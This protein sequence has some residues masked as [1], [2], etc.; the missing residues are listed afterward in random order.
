[1][2]STAELYGLDVF[3][4]RKIALGGTVVPYMMQIILELPRVGY[5]LELI[6]KAMRSGMLRIPPYIAD[7]FENYCYAKN[8]TDYGRLFDE[9]AYVDTDDGDHRK[10]PRFWIIGGTVPGL[11]EGF[12]DSGKFFYEYVVVR[13]LVPLKKA[14]ESIYNEKTLSGKARKSLE[15]FNSMRGFIEP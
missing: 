7:G 5:T 2:R 9:K 12:V 3:I 4:D 14:C 1:M 13:S 8:I 11:D 6:M 10:K 15:F